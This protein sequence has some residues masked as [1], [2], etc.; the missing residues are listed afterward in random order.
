MIQNVVFH[1]GR[2]VVPVK[3]SRTCS[4]TTNGCRTPFQRISR[5][6]TEGS[7]GSAAPPPSK[8]PPALLA[9][10]LLGLGTGPRLEK[11]LYVCDYPDYPPAPANQLLAA[12]EERHCRAATNRP[13]KTMHANPGVVPGCTDC[14]GGDAT[15]FATGAEARGPRPTTRSSNEA[16][17]ADLSRGLALPPLAEREISYA[18]L[19]KESPEFVRFVNPWTTASS[20]RVG[21]RHMDTIQA[22]KR[23]IMATGY[24]GAAPHNNGILP[25]KNYIL[26]EGY[27]RD[28]TGAAV[29]GPE[30]RRRNARASSTAPSR[31]CTAAGLGDREARRH[32]PR[33]RARPQHPQRLPETVPFPVFSSA[34]RNPGARTSVSPTVVPGRVSASPSSSSTSPRRA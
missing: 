14:H 27:T 33:L 20:R 13:I 24:T 18:L 6:R 17:A 22:A 12:A 4:A 8:I 1:P 19:N 26:G 7:F 11:S 21:A 16:R 32:L 5:R 3:A 15:V 25:F 31:S 23:S 9:T 29:V 28:G 10:V 34:S 2:G 30:P